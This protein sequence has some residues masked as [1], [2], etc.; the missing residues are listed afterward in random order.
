LKNNFKT[1]ISSIHRAG[2]IIFFA[3]ALLIAFSLPLW[4]LGMSLGQFVMA[5]GWL[6]AGKLKGRLHNAIRQPVFWLLTGLFLVH[7]TGL[8]NTEDFKYASK[9][10]RV[11]L[12]L[13][14]MPLLF[15]AGP[16]LTA[17]QLRKLF[18]GLMVGVLLSTG[19][20]MFARWGWMGEPVTNYRQLSIFISHIRLSLLIDVALV[21]AF[22]LLS[23]SKSILQKIL[24]TTFICW[25][26]YF[27]LLL[28][29]ITGIFLLS[30]LLVAGLIYTVL[31]STNNIG[32]SLAGL[33]LLLFVFSGW[34][35]YD[36]IFIQSIQEP[37]IHKEQLRDLTARGN[38]Y[39]RL[40]T[41]QRSGNRYGLDEAKQATGMV[42]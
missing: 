15:A 6:M 9:D 28:Q 39:I 23:Q 10:I 21:M 34:K 22:Y 35:I 8:W 5:G 13:L 42:Q 26:L 30:I 7:L 1:G 33:V 24:F 36:Y 31:T 3:G 25:C 4:N 19:A 16:S 2:E 12:P 40:D 20:G 14:L 37:V 32:R 41:V 11:K 27:L 18:Y 38:T 29:S 17:E